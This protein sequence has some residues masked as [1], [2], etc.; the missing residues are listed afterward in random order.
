MRTNDG[1]RPRLESSYR[2]SFRAAGR[3]LLLLAPAAALTSVVR[4]E[5]DQVMFKKLAGEH[6]DRVVSIK[7]VLKIKGG[8][9]G[10][11]GHEFEQDT[12]GLMIDPRGVVLAPSNELGGI[13]PALKSFISR[14]GELSIEPR[15]IKVMVSGDE[16]EYEAELSARD[17]DLDLAWVRLKNPEGKLF[18]AQDLGDSADCRIGQRLFV[19]D[20]VNKYFDRAPVVEEFR[21]GGITQ[22]PRRLFVPNT[23][24]GSGFCTPIYNEE[25]K[26]VGVKILQL[27]EIDDPISAMSQMGDIRSMMTG[28]ILPAQ[29]VRSAT[30]RALAAA[31]AASE[32]GKEEKPEAGEAEAE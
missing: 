18:V 16:T 31:P 2:S 19:V 3:I 12:T 23:A 9:Y 15:D 8:P 24:L 29:E 22:K 30:E 13:P 26:F 14:M 10:P 1:P 21:V 11:E 17:G 7:L 20:R 32:G 28:L 4:A 27:P 5:D 25:N 6:A